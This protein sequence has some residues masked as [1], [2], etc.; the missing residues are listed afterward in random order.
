MTDYPLTD[1]V[2]YSLI[3][4]F[5]IGF[6]IIF[7]LRKVPYVLGAVLVSIS[8][9]V[10]LVASSVYMSKYTTDIDEYIKNNPEN[11]T[12][13]NLKKDRDNMRNTYTVLIILSGILIVVN[14]GKNWKLL[15]KGK[16]SS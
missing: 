12:L 16:F 7:N 6:T 15:S 8:A 13:E 14:I 10:V 2:S 1:M 3:L 9:L 11:P 4:F 5:L